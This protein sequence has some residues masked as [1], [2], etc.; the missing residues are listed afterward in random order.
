MPNIA[1]GD[2]AP[3]FELPTDRG[4]VFRLSSHRGRPVVLFFYP[5]DGTEGCTVENIEFTE[6]LAEFEAL[7]V[8]VVGISPDSVEKHCRFRDKHGLK[9]ILVA[10]PE[11]KAID[12][13]GVWGPK[14][15]YG[16]AFDGLIR[17]SFLVG[18]DGMI[19]AAW[20]VRRIKGHAAAVLE[21]AR[22]LVEG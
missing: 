17:S 13:Y 8:A 15:L 1:V 21:A 7:G 20:T 2:K 3:D 19:A 22:Q 18:P 11:H 5:E 12:A 14:K 10:D 9:A 16:R 4:T 6:K